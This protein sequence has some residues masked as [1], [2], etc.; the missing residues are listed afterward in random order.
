MQAGRHLLS[1]INEVLDIAGIE[2]GRRT[3]S[4]EPVQ[5]GEAACEALDLVRALGQNQ[6]IEI[7]AELEGFDSRYVWADRQ[8]LQQVLLNLLSNAIKYN[9]P[10]GAVTLAC[11]QSG[12]ET[13]RLAVTDTGP[14]IP[15]E[16]L[17]RLFVPFERLEAAE[18]GIEGTGLGLAF[19]KVFVEGMGGSI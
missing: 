6:D 18:T 13:L 3:L 4:R 10:G 12:A 1:L 19:S 5:I 16:G 2:T 15:P 14:G 17:A 9:R 11:R 7:R 8:R